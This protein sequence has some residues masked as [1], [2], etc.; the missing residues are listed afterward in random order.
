MIDAASFQ[1]TFR[2]RRQKPPVAKNGYWMG[3]ASKV[4]RGSPSQGSFVLLS[5][6]IWLGSSGLWSVWQRSYQGQPPALCAGD[7]ASP[8]EPG[9]LQPKSLG[10][11]FSCAWGPRSQACTPVGALRGFY[12]PVPWDSGNTGVLTGDAGKG[13]CISSVRTRFRVLVISWT[14]SHEKSPWDLVSKI[15]AGKQETPNWPQGV[16]MVYTVKIPHIKADLE[17]WAE[18]IYSEYK[19]TQ[20]LMERRGEKIYFYWSLHQSFSKGLLK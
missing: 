16:R 13:V 8:K 10:T 14:C 4:R 17:G 3:Q 7:A 6:N 19:I 9:F 11:Y 20:L 12:W 1:V 18:D 15:K 5:Q 2:T